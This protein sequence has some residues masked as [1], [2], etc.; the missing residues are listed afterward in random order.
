MLLDCARAVQSSLSRCSRGRVRSRLVGSVL[1]RKPGPRRRLALALSLSRSSS[2]ASHAQLLRASARCT[3]CTALS[4]PP[5]PQQRPHPP[6]AS[7]PRPGAPQAHA[8]RPLA[9]TTAPATTTTHPWT[10]SPAQLTPTSEPGPPSPTSTRSAPF[11][12]RSTHL[13]PRPPAD[14]DNPTLDRPSDAFAASAYAHR[15]EGEALFGPPPRS[16]LVAPP[17]RPSAARDDGDDGARARGAHERERARLRTKYALKPE[18]EEV[19][20][21]MMQG[22][23][24]R[25]GGEPHRGQGSAQLRR[26][27]GA[28]RSSLSSFLGPLLT[29]RAGARRRSAS[30]SAARDTRPL[31]PRAVQGRL[32][33]PTR[34]LAPQLAAVDSHL[35]LRR[36]RRRLGR[37]RAPR[38][39]PSGRRAHAVRLDHA[40]RLAARRHDARRVP[41]LDLPLSPALA[42]PRALD[43]RVAPALSP[44]RRRLASPRRPHPDAHAVPAR[45]AFVRRVVPAPRPRARPAVPRP[46]VVVPPG[47][48]GPAHP[49][50]AARRRRARR[51]G[52]RVGRAHEACSG[53]R[54]AQGLVGQPGRARRRRLGEGR[55]QCVHFRSGFRRP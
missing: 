13:R 14:T 28:S 42:A 40:S 53:R 36:P 33:R 16:P 49:A 15:A 9:S 54:R 35:R 21:R 38:P 48:L 55:P 10:D 39:A 24:E 44:S 37:R 29:L 51:R 20:G 25:L 27:Q 52:A 30:S 5:P 11:S 50:R 3:A 18:Q 4:A 45:R 1:P 41:S 26:A 31:E 47:A 6:M 17:P 12:L 7:P 34:T 2:T 8:P 43:E 46:R 23:W 19:L 22:V 32:A